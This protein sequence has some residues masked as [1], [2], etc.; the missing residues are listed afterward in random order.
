MRFCGFVVCMHARVCVFTSRS[1]L[2]TSFSSLRTSSSCSITILMWLRMHFLRPKL[3]VISRDPKSGLRNILHVDTPV[4]K[5]VEDPGLHVWSPLKAW[6]FVHAKLSCHLDCETLHK[7]LHGCKEIWIVL[8]H[9]RIFI[10]PE[11]KQTGLY[12][13]KKK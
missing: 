9:L 7:A 6:W 10:K 2:A 13:N 12:V 8:I 4:A 1:S 11:N 3:S 5:N